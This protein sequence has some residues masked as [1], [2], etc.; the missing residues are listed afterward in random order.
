MSDPSQ[1]TKNGL[2]IVYG[3]IPTDDVITAAAKNA[4]NLSGDVIVIDVPRQ[5]VRELVSAELA[6]VVLFFEHT[7]EV[8]VS[9]PV[10]DVTSVPSYLV[11]I[12][13]TPLCSP[14]GGARLA[15]RL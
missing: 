10:V 2:M 9:K 1:I 8:F 6:T 15:P 7:S 3:L 14:L 13:S 12:L 5:G 4:S 11:G